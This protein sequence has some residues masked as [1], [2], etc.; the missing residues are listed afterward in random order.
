ML[1]K[2]EITLAFEGFE[3]KN[4]FLRGHFFRSELDFD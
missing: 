2:I 4:N 1:A 3:E